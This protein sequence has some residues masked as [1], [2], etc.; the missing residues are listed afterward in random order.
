MKRIKAITVVLLA[1]VLCFAA[2]AMAGESS[3]YDT[4]NQWIVRAYTTGTTAPYSIF[5]AILNEDGTDYFTEDPILLNEEPTGNP[6]LIDANQV[7]ED[8]SIAYKYVEGGTDIL[9]FGTEAPGTIVHNN[10]ILSRDWPI[11]NGECG[12]ANGQIYTVAPEGAA[13]CNYGAAAA[14]PVNN[15]TGQWN[16]TC[17]G[18][19]GGVPSGPC[20]AT[21]PRNGVCGTANGQ[22]LSQAP[23]GSVL[24][25]VGTASLVSG[26]SSGP[27]SWTCGGT[28]GGANSGTCQATF[29]PLGDPDLRISLGGIGSAFEIGETINGI[30]TITNPGTASSAV[31][32][33]CAGG[34]I[35]IIVTQG[36]ILM[37]TGY[38]N[39]MA[40]GER[41]EYPFSFVAGGACGIHTECKFR[42]MVDA[43]LC[44]R[45]TN[46]ANNAGV[47]LSIRAR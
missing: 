44:V 29:R 3:F 41:V 2:A 12:T 10:R 26:G 33:T 38:F 40:P 19:G 1:A 34:R 13:L 28:N 16:W 25:N 36:G 32:N 37:H 14:P 35:K 15:G 30:I 6:F 31:A 24:C 45:E 4:T 17:D 39:D 8:I 46:E 43:N 22:A 20:W 18:V 9:V 47:S 21:A 42:A 23:S 27:W 11:H 7:S 5:V